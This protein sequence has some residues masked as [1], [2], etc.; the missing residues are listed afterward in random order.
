[1]DADIGISNQILQGVAA[2]SR[3]TFNEHWKDAQ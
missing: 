1:M 3:T 2:G